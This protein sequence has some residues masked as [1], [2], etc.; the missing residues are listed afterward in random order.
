MAVKVACV[1]TE[2]TP[3][4]VHE[5]LRHTDGL[6]HQIRGSGCDLAVL[7]EFFAS[8]L[9]YTYDLKHLAEKI[10]P[11]G[12]ATGWLLR[13]AQTL[14][15]FTCGSL[16]EQMENGICNTFVL[17]S[18]SGT[19]MS[20]RKRY[21]PFIE[22][23]YFTRGREPGILHTPVGRIGVMLCWDMIHNRLVRE[24]DGKIDFL[25]VCAAWP[26]LHTSNIWLPGFDQW[27]SR[28]PYV[29]PEW[30]ARR[31]GVPVIFANMAGPFE[32]KIPGLG[33]TFRAQNAGHSRIL[34]A[35]A[36]SL[37][38]LANSEGILIRTIEPREFDAGKTLRTAA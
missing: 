8:G 23:L 18:P 12:Q 20:Y 35:N 28:Q 6:M 24:M 36:E 4:E 17:A 3:F 31:L 10:D 14:G 16:I 5:N 27:I 2:V 32:T 38:G 30:L 26:D 22:N 29:R 25:V 13:W 19:L 1:Q 9:R 7:P 15:T 21:H 34:A 33:L 11:S 37:G